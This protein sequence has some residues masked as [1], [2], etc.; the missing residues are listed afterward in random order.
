MIFTAENYSRLM[1]SAAGDI[2]LE[3]KCP[4]LQGGR[5]EPSPRCW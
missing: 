4:H 1:E 2:R 5:V 3:G